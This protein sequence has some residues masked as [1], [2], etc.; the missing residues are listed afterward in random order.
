MKYLDDEIRIVYNRYINTIYRLCFSYLKNDADTEDAVQVTFEKYIRC[1]KKFEN[2][3]HEKAW[4]IIT[5]GNTCKDMLRQQ[6]NK[7]LPLDENVIT[8]T[9]NSSADSE[10]LI[11]LIT[12]LP[13]KYKTVIYL[14][15]Y[16]GF[17]TKEIAG[18]LHKPPSTIRNYLTEARRLLKNILEEE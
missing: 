13:N 3:S 11:S 4:L 14:Y 2:D 5:A 15:Y 16:E 9:I 1:K 17:Q 8:T 10:N 18:F 6:Y 12:N 7:N